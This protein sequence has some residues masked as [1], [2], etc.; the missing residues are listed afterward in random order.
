MHEITIEKEDMKFSSAHFTIFEQSIERLHGHNYQVRLRLRADRLQHGLLIDFAVLKH[1][2]RRLC[3][4][5]DEHV[6]LAGEHPEL[7]IRTSGESLELQCRGKRWL[8]PAEDCCVLPLANVSCECL[9]AYFCRS[10]ADR[11]RQPLQ[12]AGVH[13]LVTEVQESPGQAGS[14]GLDLAAG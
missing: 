5:L 3:A 11:L 13:T 2:V 9:A 14:A 7:Q 8:L 10:I 4:E 1:E 6:L 12:A